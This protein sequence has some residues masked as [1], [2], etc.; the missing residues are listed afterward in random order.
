MPN[1]NG[2]E[3]CRQITRTIPQTKIIVVTASS[4][5][6]VIQAALAVGTVA[7]ITKQAIAEELLPTIKR[8]GGER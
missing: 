6:A 4:D 7:F 8:V 1:V 2:L 3:A 5:A